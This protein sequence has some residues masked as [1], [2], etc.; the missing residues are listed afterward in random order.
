M[1]I[2]KFPIVSAICARFPQAVDIVQISRYRKSPLAPYSA[3]F[4]SQDFLQ[5]VTGQFCSLKFILI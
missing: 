2:G 5:C 1:S 3:K 4:F